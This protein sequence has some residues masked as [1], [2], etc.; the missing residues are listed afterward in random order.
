MADCIRHQNMVI[1]ATNG[2]TA[3]VVE[4]MVYIKKML[5][6]HTISHKLSNLPT[7][8]LG[9]RATVAILVGITAPV[10]AMGVALGIEVSGWT[11]MK[12]RMQ[13]AADIAATAAAESFMTGASAQKAATYG[14]YIAE[15][16]NVAGAGARTWSGSATAGTLSDNNISIAVATGAGIINPSD[17]TFAVTVQTPAPTAFVGFAFPG[18]ITKTITTSAIAEIAISAG[19][20]GQPCLLTLQDYGGGTTTGYGLQISGA[21]EISSEGCTI[22]SDDGILISGS[23]EIDAGY[24][25]SSGTLEASGEPSISANGIYASA[26]SI[27]NYLSIPITVESVPQIPDPYATS[28][29][30]QA[31]FA[32]AAACSGGTAFSPAPWPAP[33]SQTIS[34]GCYSSISV[35]GD[36]DVEMNPG[37]Y[38][39][40]GN[41]T[42]GGSGE[43][44]GSG[45]TIFSNG[46]L[47]VSGASPVSIKAPKTGTSAGIAYAS[48]GTA[49]SSISGSGKFS[50]TGL[51]Y[52]P[53][54]ALNVSGASTSG[55]DDGCG[56][57]IV[58]SA[59]FSGSTS[60]SAECESYGLQ[61]FSAM[62]GTSSAKLVQ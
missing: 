44:H 38:Y 47:S 5:P 49:A 8:Q 30:M 29:V 54:G 33:T 3:E 24:V 51:L 46:N 52:Y 42:V 39:V 16:N 32:S 53:N 20:G 41:I 11:V 43:L 14:A 6:H 23:A 10:L 25:F 2:Y 56:E 28:S 19:T 35:G 48:N 15:M 45:V 7:P 55:S 59:S 57:M 22:R 40:Y 36:F 58:K 17:T 21:S 27:P 62:P 18:G 4:K 12:Q 13:R 60:L 26:K 1:Y 61:P 37:V 34:P 9:E 31:G 50:F